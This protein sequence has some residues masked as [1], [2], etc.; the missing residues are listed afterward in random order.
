MQCLCT[1]PGE[2]TIKGA[3]IA[4]ENERPTLQHIR[5][6]LSI[7]IFINYQT[8]NLM[9]INIGLQIQKLIQCDYLKSE[10]LGNRLYN[11]NTISL[12]AVQF[13]S[14]SHL[15][16]FTLEC[17]CIKFDLT[18]WTFLVYQLSQVCFILE[19]YLPI[20]NSCVIRRNTKYKGLS[21]R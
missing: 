13:Q 10:Y 12:S 7:E 8:I 21:C 6:F 3:F 20:F 17:I 18:S 14:I 9:S 2:N 5:N 11:R 16:Y 15:L 1:A 4:L 19:S